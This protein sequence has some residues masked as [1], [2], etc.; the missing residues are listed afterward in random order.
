MG[1]LDEILRE[2]KAPGLHLKKPFTPYF[3]HGLGKWINRSS[4]TKEHI[5]RLNDEKDMDIVEMGNDD[6]PANIAPERKPYPSLSEL[7]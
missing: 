2:R 3:N 6:H 4:D 5:K 7:D 1:K